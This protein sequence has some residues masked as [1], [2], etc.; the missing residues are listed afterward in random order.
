MILLIQMI[1]AEKS[2]QYLSEYNQFLIKKEIK[3]NKKYE[4]K[5]A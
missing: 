2:R 3:V 4:N 1:A 5:W